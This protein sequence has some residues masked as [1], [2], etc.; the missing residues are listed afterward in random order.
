MLRLLY[1]Q[2]KTWSLTSK[3]ICLQPQIGSPQQTHV[4]LQ[5]SIRC[6]SDREKGNEKL[7]QR[8]NYSVLENPVAY[9]PF[10]VA[11]EMVTGEWIL[12]PV[13]IW[14]LESWIW[15]HFGDQTWIFDVASTFTKLWAVANNESILLPTQQC[16]F[17]VV[18]ANS[19]CES[20]K[21]LAMHMVGMFCFFFKE[22]NLQL[23]VG[24]DWSCRRSSVAVGT[25]DGFSSPSSC[26]FGDT[27]S[28]P[29]ALFLSLSQLS[30]SL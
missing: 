8:L 12:C 3:N 20:T 15:F 18:I 4:P 24:L 7:L 9:S 29:T 17:C 26:C 6:A 10:K 14:R 28:L 5:S 23:R 16:L 1:S 30:L 2:C 27:M 19:I 13:P 25:V 21:L 11:S 22:S